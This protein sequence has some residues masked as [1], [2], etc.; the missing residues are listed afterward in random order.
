MQWMMDVFSHFIFDFT[1]F[2]TSK[3][4]HKISST[5]LTSTTIFINISFRLNWSWNESFISFLCNIKIQCSVTFFANLC[6]FTE[7]RDPS[8]I[9]KRNKVFHDITWC[10][11]IVESFYFRKTLSYWWRDSWCII[12]FILIRIIKET[13]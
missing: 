12:R 6:S 7:R 11:Y 1:D 2:R 5:L 13:T 4:L 9:Y 3:P 10:I 8:C